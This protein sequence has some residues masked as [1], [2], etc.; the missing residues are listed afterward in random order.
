MLTAHRGYGHRERDV[1]VWQKAPMSLRTELVSTDG[2]DVE[3]SA[4]T[5]EVKR[6][7]GYPVLVRLR[8][9]QTLVEGPA[10]EPGG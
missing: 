7:G 4:G 3:R 2:L 1:L 10:L 6:L 8:S 5:A 9:D